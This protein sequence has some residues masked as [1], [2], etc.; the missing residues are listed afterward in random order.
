MISRFLA[1]AALAAALPGQTFNIIATFRFSEGDKPSG[2]LIQGA[3]GNFYG[4]TMVG[5]PLGYG[6]VYSVTPAGAIN[7]VYG[8]NSTTGA[9]PVWGVILAAD[10]NFYGT[11]P[12]QGDRGSVFSLTPT[13]VFTDLATRSAPTG[14]VQASNG[15]FYGATPFGGHGGIGTLFRISSTAAF[16]TIH[17]FTGPDGATPNA[18]L[19]LASNGNLYGTTAAGGAFGHGTVFGL[20][21]EGTFKT[22]YTFCPAAGCADGNGPS[23]LVPATDGSLYGVTS[24]GGANNSGTVFRIS[25][26]GALTTLYSFCPQPG[27][28]DGSQP[29]VP[30]TAAN[31]GNFYGIT[32]AGGAT[33]Q[34]TL[35]QITPG[36]VFTKL[37]DYAGTIPFLNSGL[38]QATDGNFYGVEA[39]NSSDG[40]VYRLST[41]LAPFARPV[42][43]SG[44]PGA[45]VTILGTNLAGATAVT[46][47]SV[48]ASFTTL[49]PTAISATVPAG[50]STG[51]I[52]VTTPSDTLSSDVNF[53]VLP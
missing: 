48:A 8:M 50:A 45:A 23:G 42:P 6:V 44:A 51:K 46:F 15:Y 37:F 24:A 10:G 53:K 25:L 38:L 12:M 2:T 41:G 36:G 20:T 40:S 49:S 14:L 34:G 13:G 39:S 4:I 47:H 26:S 33:T 43:A 32:S 22:I 16:A 35:F 7:V 31:D 21:P 1:F 19:V 27:C 18:A 52:R 17:N 9:Y 11:T 3:D 5:G 28:A 29:L 30:L